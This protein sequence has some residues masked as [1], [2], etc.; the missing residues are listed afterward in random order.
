[1]Y[2]CSKAIKIFSAFSKNCLKLMVDF[3]LYGAQMPKGMQYKRV[4]QQ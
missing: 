4:T 3:L 1:M 2:S